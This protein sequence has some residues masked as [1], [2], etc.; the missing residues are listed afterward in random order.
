[1]GVPLGVPTAAPMAPA[2]MTFAPVAP[3]LR[4]QPM[5]DPPARR[6]QGYGMAPAQPQP[7]LL[8]AQPG[9]GQPKW[10]GELMIALLQLPMALRR[11]DVDQ[12]TQGMLMEAIQTL[13]NLKVHL[14]FPRGK[15]Q[16]KE[17]TERMAQ[18]VEAWT[19]WNFKEFGREIGVMLRE[20]VL[21][22]YPRR[23][24]VDES[25]RLRR[26]L[27]VSASAGIN[28]AGN[29]VSPSAFALL[30]SGVSLS[31]LVGLLAVRGMRSASSTALF[32]Q[33]QADV[34]SVNDKF[35]EVD[36]VE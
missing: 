4:A 35:I 29:V 5:A 2:G 32:H 1:M 24:S 14:S 15:L 20:F 26:Q 31:V 28:K 17:I 22:M 25:G 13:A 19:K 18:A 3:N 6:L 33:E 11:C 7:G 23:Y 34:E 9:G 27:A 36:E 16:M 21:L 30:L 8:G 12:E 10:T